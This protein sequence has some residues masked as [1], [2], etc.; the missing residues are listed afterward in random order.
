MNMVE[1]RVV[2]LGFN[3][4]NPRNFFSTIRSTITKSTH[5]GCTTKAKGVKPDF[6]GG[7][8]SYLVEQGEKDKFGGVVDLTRRRIVPIHH[9]PQLPILIPISHVPIAMFMGMMS[10][11]LATHKVLLGFRVQ[12]L[13]TTTKGVPIRQMISLDFE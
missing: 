13:I 6:N 4:E 11:I 1:E 5:Q 9:M 2:I 8:T 7:S 12:Q 3:K 10:I